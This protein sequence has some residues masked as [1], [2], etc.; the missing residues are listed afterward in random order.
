MKVFPPQKSMFEECLLM[1]LEPLN[2]TVHEAHLDLSK[3]LSSS[4]NSAPEVLNTDLF[5]DPTNNSPVV[6]SSINRIRLAS[7]VSTPL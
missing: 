7:A 6:T 3:Q 2:I 1:L 5:N 4:Q